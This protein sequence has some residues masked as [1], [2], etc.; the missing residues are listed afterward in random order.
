MALRIIFPKGRRRNEIRPSEDPQE[1]HLPRHGFA[2]DTMFTVVSKSE[3][4]VTLEALTSHGLEDLKEE[5][6]DTDLDLGDL[7]QDKFPDKE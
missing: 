7:L 4:K 1:Y 3:E 5:F 2:R 6:P